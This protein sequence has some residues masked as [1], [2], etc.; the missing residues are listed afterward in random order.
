MYLE[1]NVLMV[2]LEM[3]EKDWA[4]AESF[5]KRLKTAFLEAA[6]EAEKSYPDQGTSGHVC[7]GNKVTSKI[8]QI[9]Y[10]GSSFEKTVKMAF[11][12]SFPD[13]M[14]MELQWLARIEN[15]KVEEVLRHARVLAKQT[16]ELGAVASSTK[17]KPGKEK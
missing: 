9:R 6:F 11:V 15:M 3:G 13:R 10:R 14:L 7:S 2:Y 1:G 8:G 16:G 12:S 4:D 17:S 5:E